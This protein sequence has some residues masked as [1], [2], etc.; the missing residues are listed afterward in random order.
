M[1]LLRNLCNFV[2]DGA[3]LDIILEQL[4]NLDMERASRQMPFCFFSAYYTLTK[5]KIIT[6]QIHVALDKVIMDRISGRTLVT[7]DV[8]GSMMSRISRKSDVRCCD[9]AAL[10]G[11]MAGRLC[12]DATIYYFDVGYKWGTNSKK[13]YRIVHYGKYEFVLEICEK[14]I[15]TGAGTDLSLPMKYALEE[16]KSASI[17]PFDRIIYF[18]DNECNSSYRGLYQTVQGLADSYRSKYNPDFWIHGID[19][20]G[21]GTQ[22]FC[23][24]HFNLIAG[25]SESI[26]PFIDLAESDISTLVETVEKYEMK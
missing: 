5:E 15:F 6:P 4:S 11:A 18:S 7:V 17:K 10:L 26:L 25:W 12:E 20:M 9:I 3:N 23:G 14:S 13:G 8:S 21:Y 1:A 16:N 19:L 2:K 24:K 22:Q